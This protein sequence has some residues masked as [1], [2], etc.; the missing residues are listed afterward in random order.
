M[1]QK[2]LTLAEKW[3][4]ECTISGYGGMQRHIMTCIQK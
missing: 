2:I 1:E 4:I 3:E